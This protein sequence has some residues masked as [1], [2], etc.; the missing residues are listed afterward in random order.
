MKS[1]VIT[2]VIFAGCLE[3]FVAMS[4]QIAAKVSS[5]VDRRHTY[6]TDQLRFGGL[7]GLIST[8]LGKARSS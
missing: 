1:Q 5:R 2:P 7:L 4:A 3:A 6:P 8:R